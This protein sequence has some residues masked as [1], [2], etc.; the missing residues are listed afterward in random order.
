MLDPMTG[1]VVQ[2]EEDVQDNAY[3][4]LEE[5]MGIKGVNLDFIDS[6]VYEVSV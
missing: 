4:E 2:H 1:G 5:E 3:R 6:F